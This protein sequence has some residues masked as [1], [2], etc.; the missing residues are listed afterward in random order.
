M[1]IIDVKDEL[2]SEKQIQEM[3]EQDELIQLLQKAKEFKVSL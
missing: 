1:C 2:P 3:I